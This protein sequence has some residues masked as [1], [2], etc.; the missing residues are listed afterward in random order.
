[1]ATD[2]VDTVQ[3]LVFA[4]ADEVEQH[5][6]QA[7]RNNDINA[8]MQAWADDEDIIC[9]HREGTRL[10]GTKHVHNAWRALLT[11]NSTFKVELKEKRVI[12]CG[13]CVI[14]VLLEKITQTTLSGTIEYVCHATIVYQKDSRGWHLT[15]YMAT[16]APTTYLDLEEAKKF[17]GYFH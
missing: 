16:S 10:V 14:H 9:V 7:I 11:H 8:L 6:Y 2:K 13:M 12:N 17:P 1:M 5:F 3:R 15:M 4:S